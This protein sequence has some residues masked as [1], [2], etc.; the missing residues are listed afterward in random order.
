ML[1]HVYNSRSSEIEAE[2]YQDFKASL[3]Y[4]QLGLHYLNNNKIEHY[5][6]QQQNWNSINLENLSGRS[7]I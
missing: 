5:L 3:N 6:K 4:A 7:Q 2:E 1:T